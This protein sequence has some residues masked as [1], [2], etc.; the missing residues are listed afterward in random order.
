MSMVCLFAGLCCLLFI[1][2]CFYSGFSHVTIS[3]NLLNRKQSVCSNL[4]CELKAD[5]GE[6]LRKEMMMT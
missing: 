3:V 2:T 5:G 4:N 1:V 6:R